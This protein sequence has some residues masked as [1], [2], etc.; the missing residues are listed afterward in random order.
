MSSKNETVTLALALLI[1]T[2][3]LGGGIWLFTRGESKFNLSGV[4]A[5]RNN[6]TNSKTLSTIETFAQVQNVP[7]GLF[8]YGGSTTWSTIRGQVD[9]AI[10]T[11]WP[12]FRL[13]YTQPSK[14]TPNSS[15]GIEMLLD[16]QLSFAHSSRPVKDEEYKKAQ[17]RGFTI[18]EIPVAIDGRAVAVHPSLKI[19]GLTI[20][21]L[22]DIY[23]G[24]IRNWKEVG[25]ANQKINIYAFQGEADG[26]F[27]LVPTPTEA[28]R[29]V[30]DDPGGIF[31]ASAPLVVPQC[32]VKA[33]P[34]G[35]NLSQ[36]VS[37]YK[38]PFIP[39]DQCPAQRNTINTE[40]FQS[41]E[42]PLTRPLVVVVKQNGQ[43]DQQ[44]G[45]SYAN[46]LLTNQGQELIENAGFVRLR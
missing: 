41:G 24:K 19:P 28:L 3:L 10:Q 5:D 30:A 9:P 43:I 37:P 44:A 36:L 18:K 7:N 31:Q 21:Q 40:A 20:A 38:E 16:N 22:D 23:A 29:K 6:T 32:K 46:L 13:R 15:I 8:S 2:A 1:T 12:K 35:R 27:Q 14:G 26:K 4:P 34:L 11:V 45:E 17:Q 42:Y 25:G 33:L 39:L